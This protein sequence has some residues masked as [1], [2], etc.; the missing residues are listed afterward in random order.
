MRDQMDFTVGL[1]E[2]GAQVLIGGDVVVDNFLLPRGSFCRLENRLPVPATW[3]AIRC[4]SGD[5]GIVD[6]CKMVIDGLGPYLLEENDMG[7]FADLSTSLRYC[8]LQQEPRTTIAG[9]R[10]HRSIVLFK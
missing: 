7:V 10:R 1:D 9:R 5:Q 2:D 6:A 4:L 3:A 8:S